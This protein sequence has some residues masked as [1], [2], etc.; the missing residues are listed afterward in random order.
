MRAAIILLVLP[1]A[2]LPNPGAAQEIPENARAVTWGKG[3]VCREGH[4]ERDSRCIVLGLATDDE[5]REYLVE[6]SIRAY[7][8]NC[9]C[10]YNLDRAGR[11]CGGRSAYSRPGGASPSCYGRDISDLQVRRARERYPPPAP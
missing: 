1:L 2:V 9:P 10:P 11:R 4:V 8:G 6:A 3:W 5:I 7:S